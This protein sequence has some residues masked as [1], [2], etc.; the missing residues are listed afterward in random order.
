MS[1]SNG[2]EKASSAD[3][4][5]NFLSVANERA[6]QRAHRRGGDDPAQH[7]RCVEQQIDD[8]FEIVHD[9]ILHRAGEG[10]DHPA[11]RVPPSTRTAL[12]SEVIDCVFRF[13]GQACD[14]PGVI[15]DIA[16]ALSEASYCAPPGGVVPRP[17]VPPGLPEVRLASELRVRVARILLLGEAGSV[18]RRLEASLIGL[19]IDRVYTTFRARTRPGYRRDELTAELGLAGAEHPR[20]TLAAELDEDVIGLLPEPPGTVTSGVVG[21]GPAAPPDRLV[22]SFQLASR[23]MEAAQAFGLTGVHAFGDLG[24]LPTIVA[25]TDMGEAL[26]R[27]YVLPVDAVEYGP[28]TVTAL[29][30]WFDCGMHVDRAA[31]RLTLHPNTLRN[32]IARFE[33]LTGADLRDTAVAMQVW[34]A[35]HYAALAGLEPCRQAARIRRAG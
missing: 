31:A 25:D 2:A 11:T 24:L 9:R 23:A 5:V 21:V 28:E 26:W 13:G 20:E 6:R 16:D 8:V 35:L 34:W 12:L 10:G 22:E 18:G 15:V 4:F 30:T 29:R 19:D 1:S 14:D 27:R 17:R 7:D 32:R 33:A 3:A